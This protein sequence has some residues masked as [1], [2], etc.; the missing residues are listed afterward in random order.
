MTHLLAHADR[1]T[2]CRIL[3]LAAAMT[4]TIV[5]IMAHVVTTDAAAARAS[6]LAVQIGKLGIVAS[7]DATV[8]R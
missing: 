4:M 6:V 2:H 3:A 7:L 8:T 1:A 5:S